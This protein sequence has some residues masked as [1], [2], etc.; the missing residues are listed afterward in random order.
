M[1]DAKTMADTNPS[2]EYTSILLRQ[3]EYD[4]DN[5]DTHGS[6]DPIPSV[7]SLDPS[8]L[9]ESMD[10]LPQNPLVESQSSEKHEPKLWKRIPGFGLLL[11]FCAVCIMNG[12]NVIIKEFEVIEP[13]TLIL[14]RSLI[15]S[16]FWMPFSVC[17]DKPPFP[18]GMPKQ[19]KLLLLLRGVLSFIKTLANVYSVRYMNLGDQRMICATRPVFVLISSRIFLKESC[20]VINIVSM[21]L[22]LVGVV[23]VVKPPV[24]FG[25]DLEGEYSSMELY[26]AIG[27]FLAMALDAN[28]MIIIRKLRKEHVASMIATNQLFFALE[29]FLFILVFSMEMYNPTWP[30]KLKLLAIAFGLSICAICH[31]LSLK[32]EKANKISL[33]TNSSGIIIAFCIQILYFH[34]LPNTHSIIGACLVS[35]SVILL[36]TKSFFKSTKEKEKEK[37]LPS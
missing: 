12:V 33:M 36:T 19:D 14:Y 25:T 10:P 22:M 32:I 18:T 34:V 4:K 6:M 21:I 20:G 16:S 13:A 3:P 24:I 37:T 23:F 11:S 9:I 31:I 7:D 26:S 17:I 15:A 8:A 2:E 28:T 30:E 1:E 27:V 29:S 35:I 5:K